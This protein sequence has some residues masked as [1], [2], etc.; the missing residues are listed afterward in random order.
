MEADA[1]PSDRRTTELFDQQRHAVF[2]RADRVFAVLMVA[3]PD[4]TAALFQ[5]PLAS[6]RPYLSLIAVLLAMLAAI[7]GLA[8]YDPRRFAQVPLVA[9]V[10]R[11]AG[12][13]VFALWARQ[14]PSLPGLWV[15]AA[16]D[17]LFGVGHL[18]AFRLQRTLVAR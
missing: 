2:V 15:L 4:A 5:V 6:P 13:L 14:E 11:L 17:G 16:A 3:A 12:A 9:G 8:A 7:Y 1:R 10:G 18:G